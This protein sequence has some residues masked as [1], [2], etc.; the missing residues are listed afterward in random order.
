MGTNK[1]VVAKTV[2]YTIVVG[3]SQLALR[4]LDRKPLIQRC[5]VIQR[6][7]GCALAFLLLLVGGA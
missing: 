6:R 4:V 1:F 2:D 7:L 5:L 3:A